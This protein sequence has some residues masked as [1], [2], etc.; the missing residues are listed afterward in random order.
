MFTGSLY[1]QAKW[2]HKLKMDDCIAYIPQGDITM[3]VLDSDVN[4]YEMPLL[5]DMTNANEN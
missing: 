3:L 5:R 1:G 4:G 2:P